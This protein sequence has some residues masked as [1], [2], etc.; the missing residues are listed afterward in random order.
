VREA[1]CRCPTGRCLQPN[2][3]HHSEFQMCAAMFVGWWC[4]ACFS[5]VFADYYEGVSVLVL[6]VH[7]GLVEPPRNYV[8]PFRVCLS[9]YTCVQDTSSFVNSDNVENDG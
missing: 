3:F 8:E 6:D 2:K 4:D 7:H 5:T 1:A 9:I